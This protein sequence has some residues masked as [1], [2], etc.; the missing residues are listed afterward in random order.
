MA[1]RRNGVSTK[2]KLFCEEYIIDRDGKE[3][4]IRAGYAPKHAA[5][6]AY[7]ILRDSEVQQYIEQLYAE[8]R[9]RNNVTFDSILDDIK[10]IR[11]RCMQHKAVMVFDKEE[12]KYVQVTDPDTGEGV[13]QFDAQNALKAID[14]L[15]KHVGFYERD[16][17]Q[18]ATSVTVNTAINN[19]PTIENILEVKKLI[20][21]NL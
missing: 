4:A 12:K 18:N 8:A 9:E 13:W 14:M 5:N 2:R 1:N 7:N 6:I 21:E 3:A 15:A 11:D 16:N 17:K 10:E 20:D 19:A